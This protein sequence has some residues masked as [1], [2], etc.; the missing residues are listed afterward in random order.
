MKSMKY[1]Q[2]DENNNNN[3]MQFFKSCSEQT[4]K[5]P[6][7]SFNDSCGPGPHHHV[8]MVTTRND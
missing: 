5:H 4:C 3:L 8:L 6:V 2:Y 1:C 7:S